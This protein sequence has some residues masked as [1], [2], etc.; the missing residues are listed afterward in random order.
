MPPMDVLLPR[1]PNNSD[2][3]A[4]RFCAW[5]LRVAPALRPLGG[6]IGDD[7]EA[8]GERGFDIFRRMHATGVEPNEATLT[9][10]VC[11]TATRCDPLLAA[12]VGPRRSPPSCGFQHGRAMLPWAGGDATMDGRGCYHGVCCV[13]L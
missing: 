3:G 8:H 1:Q 11:F 4:L 13:L 9:K 2:V 6:V 5:W 10:V 12:D 7:L